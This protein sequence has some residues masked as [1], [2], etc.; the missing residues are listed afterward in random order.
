MAFAYVTSQ[1]HYLAVLLQHIIE[2]T[3][4]EL[5]TKQN[6][7]FLKSSAVMSKF[8]SYYTSQQW[9]FRKTEFILYV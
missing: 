8:T 9:K 1:C 7:N 5:Y 4:A 6:L 2:I 3:C